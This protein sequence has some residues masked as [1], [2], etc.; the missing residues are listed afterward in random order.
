M[1][2]YPTPLVLLES[3][4]APNREARVARVAAEGVLQG[5]A[6]RGPGPPTL[7]GAAA[8]PLPLEGDSGCLWRV[9]EKRRGPAWQTF[10]TLACTLHTL[11]GT[12][13]SVGINRVPPCGDGWNAQ[14]RLSCALGAPARHARQA[15]ARVERVAY[16][17][18]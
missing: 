2:H 17:G 10:W 5:R 13:L 7:A 12:I 11:S 3:S 4:E 16:P 9:L 15:H 14:G 8:A 18:P 6:G 1:S